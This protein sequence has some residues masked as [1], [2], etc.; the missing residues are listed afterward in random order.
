MNKETTIVPSTILQN[1]LAALTTQLQ[2]MSG[3][4]GSPDFKTL[5]SAINES[6]KILSVFY[7]RLSEPGFDPVTYYAD[8]EPSPDDYNNNFQ[9][10][11]NDL[12]VLFA[13]FENLEGVVLGGFNYMVTRLNRLTTRMKRVSSLVGDYIIYSKHFANDSIFF[14]DSF[15][16]LSRVDDHSPL[17]NVEQCE[18]NQSEG[19][20]TLPINRGKQKTIQIDQLPT[21]NN[22]SNGFIG[23]NYEIGATKRGDLSVILDNNADTW[24]E[25]E[26]VVTSDDGEALVLDLTINLGADQIVNSVTIKPNNFGTRTQV[27]VLS[28]DTSINGKEFISVKD[29]IPIADFLVEDEEN[30]FTLAPSTSN[31]AGQGI[32]SFTPRKTRYI[33]CVLRQSSAYQ[34]QTNLGTKLRYAIGI[35][36]IVIEALPYQTVGEL[37]STE[38]GTQNEI[39]KVALYSNQLPDA[40]TDSSLAKIDHFIS[41][42]NGITWHQIRPL[43]S[44]GVAG[45]TQTI[46]EIIDFNGVDSNSIK[47]SNP[48]F[49]V[50]YKARLERMPDAFNSASYELAQEIA[51]G[52]ELHQVPSVAPF[53]FSLK[54]KPTPNS[55][56]IIDPS[57]GARGT[58]GKRQYKIA[59]G[60][61]DKLKVILP[62]AP[63]KRNKV[64]DIGVTPGDVCYISETDAQTIYV[65][66]VPWTRLLNAGGG[67]PSIATDEHYSLNLDSGELQFGDGTVG[68]A[69]PKG[70]VVSISL[71]EEQVYPSSDGSHIAKLEYPTSNDKKQCKLSFV[72]G[73]TRTNKTLQAGSKI[74]KL[75]PDMLS[76]P[77]PTFSEATIFVTERTFIDGSSEFTGGAG[78]WSIDYTNGVLYSYS[79]VPVST[80]TTMTFYYYLREQISEDNW[81][82][83]DEGGIANAI[84]INDRAWRTLASG[85]EQVPSNTKYFG[86]Y[87]KGVIPGSL[88]FYDD[89]DSYFVREIPF[90]DGK[91]ELLGVVAASERIDAIVS[92]GGIIAIP[93]KLKVVN[94]IQYKVSFTNSTV[95]PPTQEKT[96]YLDI[97]IAGDHY[98]DKANSIYYVMVAGSVADPGFVKYYYTDTNFSTAGLFS[99]NYDTGEVYTG[100]KTIFSGDAA[101]LTY[102]Y[103]DYRISYNIAR[104]IPEDDWTLDKT[105]NQVSI[106]DREILENINVPQVVTASSAS[107]LYQASY[108]YIASSRDSLKE[109]EPYFSPA[110]RDYSLEIVTKDKLI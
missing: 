46:P 39:R 52:T 93:F 83:V 4:G 45:A 89:D 108:K 12:L 25:Y 24:F 63:I 102:Q 88:K 85:L 72:Y 104:E 107:K 51:N 36:D 71:S 37:I 32:Y 23:N 5:E 67:T 7:K 99:V 35:R 18:V 57:L 103:T 77:A 69:V 101:T 92:S 68:K 44:T 56:K 79:R 10:V 50:R 47:T 14:V 2:S 49:G 61:A 27:E 73:K 9:G 41:P 96:A 98:V 60:N 17:L 81:D 13:E 84:S 6:I 8:T 3:P 74:N 76:D 19:I 11:Y 87:N 15:N 78:D 16:N 66:G 109:L 40:S 105:T 42:D 20:I 62:F 34:I 21:I 29:E 64:K 97:T 70:S 1:K 75:E 82:F 38:Y 33:K 43:E 90:V 58:T 30:V 86:L 59:T 94:S 31:Y 80:T 91:T 106:S 65:D 95:F 54:Q 110:V 22:S 55:L 48:V 28:L 26:R 53:S 100:E